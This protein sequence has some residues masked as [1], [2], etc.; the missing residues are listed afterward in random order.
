MLAAVAMYIIFRQCDVVTPCT[1][2]VLS[3]ANTKL[4]T[5]LHLAKRV[6]F[7]MNFTPID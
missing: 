1:I 7:T 3:L 4:I 6:N 5:H 2:R